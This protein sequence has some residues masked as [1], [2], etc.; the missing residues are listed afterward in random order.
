MYVLPFYFSEVLGA[1]LLSHGKYAATGN[2]AVHTFWAQNCQICNKKKKK[3]KEK[4][5]A[6]HVPAI[7]FIG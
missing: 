1:C 3:R 2:N 4:N 6:L 7:R 5:G